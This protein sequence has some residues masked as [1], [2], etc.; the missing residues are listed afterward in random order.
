M[1]AKEQRKKMELRR[2]KISTTVLKHGR[3]Q[4][5]PSLR[6]IVAWKKQRLE[7]S[8][9]SEFLRTKANFSRESD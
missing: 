8:N 9:V 7:I 6:E 5:T 4:K 2:R 3:A 1:I